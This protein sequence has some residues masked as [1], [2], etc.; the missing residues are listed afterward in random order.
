MKFFAENVDF[1]FPKVFPEAENPRKKFI[2][3]RGEIA[4]PYSPGYIKV[5]DG[6]AA[7]LVRPLRLLPKAE[8][9][10]SGQVVS[11]TA[12]L[13]SPVASFRRCGQKSVAAPAGAVSC[14]VR[15]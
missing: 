9:G 4:I 3:S 10:V 7:S 5:D 2:F 15:Q 13:E 11:R 14:E 12:P 6:P 1:T 8:S